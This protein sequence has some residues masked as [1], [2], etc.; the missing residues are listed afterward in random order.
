[1]DHGLAALSPT[2]GPTSTPT[3]A[4]TAAQ[5]LAPMSN[6]TSYPTMSPPM[7]SPTAGPVNPSGGSVDSCG[8]EQSA[9]GGFYGIWEERKNDKFDWS[10][11]QSTPSSRTGPKGAAEGS[12]F[13]YIE[14]SSPRKI[15]DNAILSAT[16]QKLEKGAT[17]TFKYLMYGRDIDSLKVKVGGAVEFEKRGDKGTQWLS[18]VMDLSQFAGQTVDIDIEAT[19]GKTWRSDIA[20]DD[21]SLDHGLA[22]LSPTSG[23][24]S[25]PTPAPTAAQPLAPLS[26]PTSYPTMSP[27]M[28]SP[29]SIPTPAP[30]AAQTPAPMSNPTSNQSFETNVRSQLKRIEDK[31]DALSVAPQT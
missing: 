6:P 17:L 12:H 30:T 15:G 24:T 5:P 9:S 20:I 16:S 13:L 22:A 19:R 31:I 8:F 27:P 3:P 7:S 25:T 4:P 14:A 10:R 28:S 18:A 23:P 1:L 21:I 2:S 29:I 11:G 26:N